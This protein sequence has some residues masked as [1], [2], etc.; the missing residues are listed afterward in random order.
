MLEELNALLAKKRILCKQAEL[1]LAAVQ[2]EITTLENHI[3]M[4]KG[5]GISGV[6]H[7][8]KAAA[9][10][11]AGAELQNTMALAK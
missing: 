1:F 6:V 4:L 10:D 3:T 2:S 7:T 9:T 5:A 8:Q 11:A